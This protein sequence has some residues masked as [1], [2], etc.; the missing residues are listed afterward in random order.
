MSKLERLIQELCP[1]GVEMKKIKDLCTIS[2]GKLNA[3]AMVED[4]KYEFF[5]CSKEVFKTNTYSFDGEALLI[6]G[7]GY[8]GDVKHY[9]GKFDAYQRTYV[10]MNFNPKI[11]VR[12]M[13]HYFKMNFRDYVQK[14]QKEGS[15]P[16]ITLGTLEDYKLPFPPIEV[17]SEIVRILDNFTLLTAELTAELT[18]RKEQYNFYLN[19]LFSDEYIKPIKYMTVGDLFEFKNGLNK[20]KEAF[21][22]GTPIVN[23]TDVYKKR[24]LRSCDLK[25]LVTL[26]L[27]EVERY[28][29]L[30]GDVFF[31]RTS[32]TLEDIGMSSTVVEDI[33]NCTFSGFVLRARPK[34]KLFLPKFCAYFFSTSKV[35]KDIVRY[36]SYTTRATTSGPKLSKINMP[37]ISIEKQAEIINLLDKFDSYCNDISQGLPAEIELRQKQYEYYRNKLLTFKE[38]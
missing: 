7:N 28:K 16:Y 18:A 38:L 24:F 13:Y 36:A 21:G 30:K 15:V 37:I 9:N 2:T 33:P 26:T 10:L 8:I 22:Q 4:G 19:Y 35:R 34:T 27:Q 6:A 12:F 11:N 5:T 17:Q 20:E 1:N 32:E 23:F 25:G 29:V 14:F 3:N 31:T